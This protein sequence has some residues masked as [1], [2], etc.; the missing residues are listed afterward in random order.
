MPRSL[1]AH[2]ALYPH[3]DRNISV[4]CTKEE[5]ERKNKRPFVMHSFAA[6]EEEKEEK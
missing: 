1:T 2:L 3:D 5:E 6:I 4:N